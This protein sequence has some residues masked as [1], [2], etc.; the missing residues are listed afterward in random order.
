MI[1]SS[2]GGLVG[3]GPDKS[4]HRFD[5]VIVGA[6]SAGCVLASR[7]TEDPSVS[8]LLIEAGPRA[9]GLW[10]VVPL[11][12]GKLLNRPDVTWSVAAGPEPGLDGRSIDWV[13]GRVVGGSSVLNGMLFVRGHAKK[14]DEWAAAGCPA[15]S[16]SNVEPLFSRIEDCQ[17]QL[18]G[19][20]SRSGPIAASRVQPDQLSD[21]FLESCERIG[22]TRVADYNA[23]GPEGCSYLQLS[24]RNG[25]RDSTARTYF[26]KAEMRK[27]LTVITEAVAKSVDFEGRRARGVNFVQG[28]VERQV[29]ASREVIL[30]AGAVRTPQLLELSGVGCPT[31]LESLGIPIVNPLPGVGENLQDHLMV[32][33]AYETYFKRTVNDMLRDR[34]RL[35]R[36]VGQFAL[37]RTGLLSTSSLTATAFVN[38]GIG[39]D[40]A[41]IRVQ[42]GLISSQ[43]RIV[44]GR[45]GVDQH[46]G[47]HL[48]SY[49]IFPRSR[50]CVHA[51]TRDSRDPPDVVAGYLR[52]SRDIDVAVRGFEI[53]REIA[54]ADPLRRL[55]VGEVRPSKDAFDRLS[56]ERYIRQTGSTC[57]HPVGTCRMGNDDL[58]VVDEQLLVRGL[59]GIRVV[60]A[61][62]MPS[63]PSSNTNIPV[64]MIAER[65]ADFI[66]GQ[67]A[68]R[69]RQPGMTANAT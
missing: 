15:W 27:N 18:T 39:T 32:R 12:V 56:I 69:I 19:S 47:F 30:C 40:E 35:L 5:Y 1:L 7:L 44:S 53:S 23:T 48:G 49:P 11:G 21:A 2:P 45:A 38:S 37:S 31:R 28:G 22:I 29:L 59:E 17:F 8:V 63:L 6:G 52:D 46:S 10:G 16:W 3:D 65:A 4:L 60:D 58:A 36:E 42:L 41:D 33:I 24:T 68:A 25:L 43:G 20:R 13:S 55:I 34:W 64:V 9:A 62:V 66:T 57:W 67:G 14:Y 61:S 51:R 50:G 54:A 26:A